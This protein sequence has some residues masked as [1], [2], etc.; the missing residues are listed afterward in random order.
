MLSKPSITALL[1]LGL[2]GAYGCSGDESNDA[3][4]GIPDSGVVADSG[5]VVADS[6]VV[7]DTGVADS[8]TPDSGTQV[9]T[10]DSLAPN[11]TAGEAA[12][13]NVG[14]DFPSLQICSG[15]DDFFKITLTEGQRV[16]V[17]IYFSHAQGDLDMQIFAPGDL[18]TPIA[19]GASATDD[20]VVGFQADVAGEYVIRVIGY[21]DAE[22]AYQ[23]SVV[24]GCFVDSECTAPQVCDRRTNSCGAYVE[25]ACGSDGANDPNGSNGQAVVLDLSSGS[26]TITG[27][28]ACVEDIDFF[29]FTAAAGDSFTVTLTPS[30]TQDGF[31]MFLVDA[32]GQLYPGQPWVTP[33]VADI[34]HLAAG[35]WY[36]VVIT[37]QGVDEAYELTVTKTAGACMGNAS[38]IDSPIGP[39]CPGGVCGPRVGNGLVALGGLCDDDSDCVPE[40]EFCYNVSTSAD[41]FFCNITCEA[42]ADCAAIGAGAYCAEDRGVC[43]K[44]CN[45]NSDLCF[46]GGYCGA[47]SNECLAGNCNFAAGCDAAG[48]ECLWSPGAIQGQ[49]GTLAAPTCGQGGVGEPN[50]VAASATALTLANG[51]ATAMGSIC[52]ADADMYSFVITEPS[53]VEVAVTWAGMADVDFVVFPDADVRASGVG[54]GT[55]PQDETASALFLAPGTYYVVVGPYSV[56]TTPDMDYSVTLTVT[57]ATCS[58]MTCLDTQPLR[59]QCDMSGACVDFAGNGAVALG[60]ACDDLPDCVPEADLCFIG[61][62]SVLN[63]MCSIFCTSD[64]ECAAVIPGSVCFDLGIGT[65]GCGME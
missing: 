7:P 26:T 57:A 20:E 41:G 17:G 27:L 39:F 5:V 54:F 4:T 60:G 14:D 6:G 34:P 59:Q 15:A 22:A 45:G 42:D 32:A 65:G 35:T 12:A 43:D 36:I 10:E 37:G 58:A 16:S 33:A 8:G 28:S 25:A 40:A 31:G 13:V 49:C 56:G 23:L 47:T 63:H 18:T 44:P 30:A 55:N 11:H 61:Q 62:T 24:A 48:L 51:T 52:A 3:G 21:E 19:Q 38:C 46:D 50:D 2:A 64:A 29:T 9:C 53:S 1:L